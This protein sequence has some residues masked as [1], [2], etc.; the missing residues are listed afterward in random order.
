MNRMFDKIQSV[1]R[2]GVFHVLGATAINKI[3]SFVTNIFLV[4]ILSKSDYGVFSSS[5]N[6]FLIAILF[7][8]LGIGSSILYYASE[9]EKEE[10]RRTVYSFAVKYGM[11]VN[12]LICVGIAIY[13]LF[14]NVGIE[15]TRQYILGLA[16]LPVFYFLFDY[17]AHVLRTRKE[18]KKFSLLLNINTFSYCVLAVIGSWR[19]G[20]WGTIIGRY[21]SYV[22]SLIVGY[23]YAKEYISLSVKHK[24]EKA[25][26]KQIVS[27]AI[28][29]GVVAALNQ[30]LYRIDITIITMLIAD[31]VILANYKVG[32]VVPENMVFIPSSISIVIVPLFVEHNQDYRWVYNKAKTLFKTMAVVC[33]CVSLSMFI[34]AKPIVCILW[35]KQYLDSVP[36]FRVLSLSFF[37]LGTFR[38]TS[39]NILQ[40]IGKVRYNLYVST[41]AGV[42]NVALDIVMIMQF[43]VIGAAYATLLVTILASCLSFP[44]LIA[45]LKKQ[46]KRMMTCNDSLAMEENNT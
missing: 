4:R 43:G 44:Y 29:S 33:G 21:L 20:I 35:G 34:F 13:G 36:F 11:V 9:K 22:I 32:A 1:F 25:K 39:T 23:A 30:I 38:S 10:E 16:F 15:E 42:S 5:F 26:R 45:Q 24:V 28:H 40:A 8:G 46:K 7:N 18:N 19:W 41:I 31:S 2:L 3:V 6:V 37:F 17:F 12:L 27:Y 14:F